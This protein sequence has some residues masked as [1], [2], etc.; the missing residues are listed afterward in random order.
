M[1]KNPIYLMTFLLIAG[2]LAAQQSNPFRG[3]TRFNT[4]GGYDLGSLLNVR[5]NQIS[6]PWA[7]YAMIKDRHCDAP[8]MAV[9]VE[10]VGDLT[11]ITRLKQQIEIVIPPSTSPGVKAELARFRDVELSYKGSKRHY[12]DKGWEVA[13]QEFVSRLCQ[14][15]LTNIINNINS[16]RNGVFVT[17][18]VEFDSG[19]LD[20]GAGT[21]LSAEAKQILSVAISASAQWETAS[22]ISFTSGAKT[23]FKYVSLSRCLPH[24]QRALALL[25]EKGVNCDFFASSQL[26]DNTVANATYT[27]NPG[28]VF[29]DSEF[30][31]NGPRVIFDYYYTLSPDNTRIYANLKMEAFEWRNGQRVGDQ[32]HGMGLL[33]NQL[34]YVAPTGYKISEI[35]IAYQKYHQEDVDVDTDAGKDSCPPGGSVAKLTYTGDTN[36]PD[37]IGFPGTGVIIWTASFPISLKGCLQVTT[38]D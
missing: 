3:Y 14:D 17:E 27:V 35:P 9:K 4:L 29:G 18:V 30:F 31:G 2:N 6:Q 36:G 16:S 15:E 28:L 23:H 32:S 5:G 33:E 22:V 12:Y 21:N 10:H 26:T 8:I 25:R 11:S 38:K 19:K 1:K 34:Y 7:T 37:L 24:A 20:I 13:F